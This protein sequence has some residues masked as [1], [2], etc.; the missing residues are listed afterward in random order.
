MPT[1]TTPEY[2]CPDSGTC[3][4]NCRDDMDGLCWRTLFAAPLSGVYP[5]DDYWPAVPMACVQTKPTAARHVP[6]R[7]HLQH[8]GAVR[9]RPILPDTTGADLAA[10]QVLEPHR[11]TAAFPSDSHHY[12]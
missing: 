4:H 5:P 6:H 10:V 8:H 7:R 9:S 2:G 11:W 3:H 1:T 12:R